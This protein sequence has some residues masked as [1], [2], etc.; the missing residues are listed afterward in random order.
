MTRPIK[1]R[2][3]NKKTGRM[4]DP[5]ALTPLAL[6]TDCADL[7]GVFLPFHEE[8]ELMQFTGLLDRQGKEIYEGDV[9]RYH[10]YKNF[11]HHEEAWV[12]A[13]EWGE[14]GD[15]DGW[16]HGSH[17]EWVVGDNSLADV[18]GE[19]CVVI[20]NIYENPELLEVQDG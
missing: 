4:I 11:K 16:A 8:V 1:F 6:N 9:V 7:P 14:T 10:G 15:S 13:V 17:F 5:H 3:W 2:A 19:W 20:G 12:D 18:Y